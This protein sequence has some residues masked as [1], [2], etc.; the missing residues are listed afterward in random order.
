MPRLTAPWSPWRSLPWRRGRLWSGSDD[1]LIQVTTDDG[2]HWA[3]VTPK[4]VRG[5]Y[6]ADLDASHHDKAVAYAAIDGH[7]SDVYDPLILMTTDTGRTWKDITGDLPKGASAR[8]VREDIKNPN[9]LY[10]GTETGVFLSADKG[11]HW[12]RLNGE[13]LPTVGVHDIRQQPR[14]MDLVI[15]THGRSVWVMDDASALS[16]LTPA[17]LPRAFP[18]LRRC[19]RSHSSA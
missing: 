7:R 16:Q 5:W 8:V 1:G 9:V 2:A 4:A 18:C 6:V 11:Q 3:N 10:C 14:T 19:R 15:A 12:I 13:S 17:L